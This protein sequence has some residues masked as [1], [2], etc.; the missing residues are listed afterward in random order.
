MDILKNPIQTYHE[1]RKTHKR[2]KGNHF[3]SH[4]MWSFKEKGKRAAIIYELK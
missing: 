4:F 1:V 2:R 3:L